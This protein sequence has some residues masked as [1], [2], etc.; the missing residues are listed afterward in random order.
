MNKVAR[1]DYCQILLVSQTNYTMTYL[2]EHSTGF[3]HD[4]VKQYLEEDKLT[5]RLASKVVSAV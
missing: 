5:D 1:L 2:A 4:A 3:S